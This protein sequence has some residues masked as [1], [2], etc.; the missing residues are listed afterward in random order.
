[1]VASKLLGPTL[2]PNTPLE[3]LVQIHYRSHTIILEI[4]DLPNNQFF[5]WVHWYMFNFRNILASIW[6]NGVKGYLPVNIQLPKN[7]DVRLATVMCVKG[8]HKTHF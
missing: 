7:N 8:A 4:F 5:P 2:R 6:E 3:D 1:M